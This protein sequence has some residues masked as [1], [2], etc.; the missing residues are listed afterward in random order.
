MSLRM[1]LILI[2]SLV[3]AGVIIVPVMVNQE[4]AEFP[5]GDIWTFCDT[6]GIWH[7]YH[8]GTGKWATNARGSHRNVI[9]PTNP[10]NLIPVD[11]TSLNSHELFKPASTKVKLV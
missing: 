11:H 5:N 4:L 10:I 8:N 9:L 1:I 7:Y 3:L 2:V 6:S